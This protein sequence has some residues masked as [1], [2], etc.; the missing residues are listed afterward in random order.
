M[1]LLEQPLELESIFIEENKIFV[2]LFLFNRTAKNLE[3]WIELIKKVL[4]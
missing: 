4:I 1:R 2:V 3:T